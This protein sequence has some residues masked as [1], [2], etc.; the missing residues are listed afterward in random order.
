MSALHDEVFIEID[1]ARKLLAEFKRRP[2][3]S[4]TDAVPKAGNTAD[5]PDFEVMASA[6]LPEEP[7]D[8]A[9]ILRELAEAQAMERAAAEET[10]RKAS[11]KEGAAT[12][13]VI[14]RRDAPPSDSIRHIWFPGIGAGH[15]WY[16]STESERCGPV[17]FKE[18]RK[19]AASGVLD[20]RMDMVWK[21]GTPDWKPAGLVD[22]LFERNIVIEQAAVKP[23][24]RPSP[25]K[26]LR[27]F[28]LIEKLTSSRIKWPGVG[29]RVLLPVVLLFPVLWHQLLTLS[30][31]FLA[32][33][34]G[35]KAVEVLHPILA[36]VPPLILAGLVLNRMSNLG[37]NRWWSLAVMVPLLNLWVAFRCLFCPAGY[38]Y[39]RKMDRTGIILLAVT[40]LLTP[41]MW[42]TLRKHPVVIYN[43]YLRTGLRTV[44]E[45]AELIA[46]PHT[47]DSSLE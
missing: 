46:L 29:R 34:L 12:G 36:I 3:G 44:V 41:F 15:V 38:A 45:H 35:T 20:P 22:G 5:D 25:L 26:S 14:I 39:H 19:M 33:W 43:A 18:L 6:D 42:Q 30:Y 17:T 8:A 1:S 47:P 21:K 23:A 31:P 24:P 2:E 11:E 10:L 7:Q 32:S 28:A 27:S 16:F 4:P 40:V 13:A 9:D 37:M